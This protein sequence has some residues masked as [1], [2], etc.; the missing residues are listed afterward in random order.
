MDAFISTIASIPSYI[1]LETSARTYWLYL[2][3]ACL[4][5]LCTSLFR[6][7]RHK[8][9]HEEE[10]GIAAVGVTEVV[11]SFTHRSAR[12]D[13]GFFIFG[14]TIFFVI[15]VPLLLSADQVSGAVT[16]AL[17]QFVA[18]I[19]WEP[20]LI[21]VFSILITLC[22]VLVIDFSLFFGHMLFHR[23]GAFWEFHKVHH[24]AEVLNPLTI[25]RMHPFEELCEICSAFF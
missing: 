25:Y 3:T 11:R 6:G 23:I 19:H 7:K 21:V 9:S 10:K 13:Y 16:G 22:M 5:A 20:P 2:V 4:I 8:K 1:F 17:S 24:S 18:P 12:L 14:R 15:L